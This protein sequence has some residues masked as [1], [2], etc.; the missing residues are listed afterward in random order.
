MDTN[1]SLASSIIK[2]LQ[3]IPGDLPVYVR[4]KYS[5]NVNCENDYPICSFGVNEMESPELGKHITILY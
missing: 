5:V 3:M 2:A 1:Q 4:S